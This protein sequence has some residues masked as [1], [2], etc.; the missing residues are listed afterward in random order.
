ML[1]SLKML[2]KTTLMGD[3]VD[4]NEDQKSL[5]QLVG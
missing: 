2:P 5:D 4:K 3:T 1:D